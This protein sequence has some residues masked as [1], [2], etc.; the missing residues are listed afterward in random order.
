MRP[1][2]FLFALLSFW[3]IAAVSAQQLSHSTYLVGHNIDKITFIDQ[4]DFQTFDHIY[5][6]AAP[7]WKNEDFS[8][9]EEVL[10]DHLVNDFSYTIDQ[11]KEV[12]PYLIDKAHGAN[13]KVM[14]SFAGEGFRE[15]VED[16]EM[17]EKF[18]HFIVAFIAK[19]K[20]D[21]VEIDWESDLSLPLHALFLKEIRTGLTAIE[22]SLGKK[23]Y[24]TT[25]LHSWQ[26]YD[27]ALADDLASSVDWINVMTYDMGGG[28][29]GNIATHNTPLDQ[30]EKEMKNWVVFNP[31]QLCIGLANYG[32]IYKGLK[33]NEK[34]S[35][36]L[37]QFGAYISYNQFLPLLEKGWREQYDSGAEVSYFFSPDHRDF[38][39]MD[40]PQSIQKK[41]EWVKQ[42]KY[43]G[44]FWWEFHYDM[45]SPSSATGKIHHHLIDLVTPMK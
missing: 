6:M 14:L 19:Y 45:I 30:I 24:L 25:A 44:V 22:P 16:E 32:F 4:I 7:T 42:Q 1:R 33:P 26:K 21:G 11:G 20:F 15:R 10:L 9:S 38:I 29:W 27:K 12:I 40:T 39:T 34:I 31:N 41:V 17:R 2:F 23:L 43:N 37:N 36:K 3:G 13:T 5:L 18:V 8:Q 28:T 35:G